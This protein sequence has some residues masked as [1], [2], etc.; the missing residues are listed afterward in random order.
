M[1]ARVIIVAIALGFITTS[2]LLSQKF[3]TR[4]R[5]QEFIGARP[6]SMGETFIAVADD[7]NAIYWNPA[8]LPALNHLGV[9]SMHTNLFNSGVGCNYL[10][11]CIP[12]FPKTSIGVDWMNINF[13][14]EELDFGKNKFNFSAGYK[15][16]EWMSLGFS[17]KYVRMRAALDQMSQGTFYGWGSDMG[18]LCNLY[19][20]LKLGLVIHDFT[21]TKMKGIEGS[22][23]KQN[24]RIGAAYQL[25][26]NLL[27]ATDLDDR[28]HIGTEWW[29]FKKFLALRGGLQQDFYTDESMTLSFGIGLDVP[30][31][32]QRMR[33]DYA[34][35]DTPTLLNTNR[36][37]LSFLID[38][39]PRLV[40]IKSVEIKPVYASLYKFYEENPIGQVD[41]EYKGK[42]ELDCTVSVSV[43]KYAK[44]R[45][46]N[47][48]LSPSPVPEYVQQVRINPA[49]NDS[50][51]YEQD[52]IPL[53]A[54]IKISYLSGVRPKVETV[55]HKFNLYRRNKIDW[56][57]GAEQAVAFI[58]PE[59]QTVI[60]FTRN[61]LSDDILQDMIINGEVTKAVQLFNAVSRYGI[62]YE[63]DP[64]SPYRLTYQSID[65][66]LYPAQLLNE[67]RGDCDDLCVLLASL[68]ENRNI[69][70][71]L[72]SVPGHIFLLLNSGIHPKRSFQL[73]CAEDQYLN[74]QN[75]LWIPLETTWIKRSF[76]AAWKEGANQLK[77]H[78][79]NLEIIHVREAWKVYKPVAHADKFIK[80]F[81]HFPD[82]EYAQEID[83]IKKTLK[84]HLAELEKKVAQFPDSSQLRNELA[85]KYAFQ[86]D[87]ENSK[88]HFQRLLAKDSTDFFALNNLGNLFFMKGNLDSA[89]F[90]YEEASTYAEGKDKDGIHLN[91]GLI[92]AAAGLDSEAVDMFTQVMQDSTDYQKIG[93]L[94]GITIQEEDLVKGIKLK[95]KKR[96]CKTTVKQLTAKAKKKKKKKK[97]PKKTK[98]KRTIAGKGYLPKDEIENVFYWAN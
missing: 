8:G 43:N 24:L 77:K 76:C 61:A 74:Y 85:I 87:I 13:S 12:G 15:L 98:D 28:L 27:I 95:P 59:D 49:F 23:Y 45:T 17:L 96:I 44:E 57:Y 50:I 10:A 11:L 93:D 53:I 73:C 19:P 26:D 68:L 65:N 90:Y 16:F 48:I 30:I 70:T 46:K 54:D 22:I 81:W 25:F 31:W 40:K 6:M 52:N 83:S 1:K 86:N 2:N 88:K 34:F 47:I 62:Q 82:Q 72:V 37:S 75:Q 36:Y 7:I 71:A 51:L 39:F 97:S 94:L 55:S 60:Q 42:K 80:S 58:T 91:L 4:I 21:N 20:K 56:Q 33:F 89:K 69:P 14:D 41:I 67:K 5:N 84:K 63:E 9:N 32:G 18:V 78:S 3:F 38:L 79:E 29:P 92:Y 35:T 66:I 64:Y